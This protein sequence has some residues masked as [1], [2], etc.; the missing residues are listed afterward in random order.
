MIGYRDVMQARL[1]GHEVNSVFFYVDACPYRLIDGKV[2]SSLPIGVIVAD[3]TDSPSEHS[4]FA[5]QGAQVYVIA[6]T[7]ERAKAFGERIWQYAPHKLVMSAEE[8]M[9]IV[10][11]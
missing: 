1:D 3:P 2:L 9:E 7:V 4:F 6:G 10:D 8:Y 11:V 5:L